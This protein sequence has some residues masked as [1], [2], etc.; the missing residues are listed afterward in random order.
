[1][2]CAA[3]TGSH[4]P[5]ATPA[6]GICYL[7]A[8]MSIVAC[9]IASRNY[10]AYARVFA[11]S[12]REHHPGAEVVLCLVDEPAAGDDHTGEPFN[13]VFA[14]DLDI[15]GFRSLA[16]RYGVL[17]LNTAVKPFLLRH[18]RDRRGVDRCF[19]FDPDIRVLSPL[20]ELARLLDHHPLLLTPHRLTPA[21]D[22][23]LVQERM[24]L[25]SGAYNLGFLGLRLDATTAPFLDWWAERLRRFCRHDVSQGLF[26]DQR[27]M[28][29]APSLVAD[30]GIVRDPIY[31]V[32]YWNLVERRPMPMGGELQLDGRAL[33]FFH[34][35]GVDLD[36]LERVSRYQ[37]R[38]TLADRPEL[39]PLFVDYRDR[40]LA[41]GHR[42]LSPLP[43]SYGRFDNGVPL[44]PWVRRL[45]DTTDPAA[46]RW[47]DPFCVAAED[48][49][50]AWLTT[51]VW[52]D[53][54]P[55]SRAA[56]AVWSSSESLRQAIPLLAGGG[57]GELGR[58]LAGEGARWQLDPRLLGQPPE[59]AA[60]P[61]SPGDFGEQIPGAAVDPASPE[62]LL[63]WLND[64]IPGTA[65]RQPVITRFALMLHGRRPDLATA[66]PD[67][68]GR[69]QLRYAYWFCRWGAAE[70]AADRRLV[71]PIERTL[72][73]RSRFALVWHRRPRGTRTAT[74]E[75]RWT[76]P[77][78]LAHLGGPR[79]KLGVNVAGY[80][81]M[82]TG[83]A[84]AARGS[85]AA[86]AAAGM[87]TTPYT[88]ASAARTFGPSAG[89]DGT[90]WPLTLLHANA[91]E[92]P[93]ALAELGEGAR[94]AGPVVGYWFWELA[95]FPL[96]YAASFA[97]LAEVWTASS[98]AAA[99]IAGL[100]PV[101][102]RV[103]APHVP[104]PASDPVERRLLGIGELADDPR[105]LLILVSFDAR[106]GPE[107]KN[108]WAAIAALRELL[109][110]GVPGGRP[111]GLVLR[112]HG[113]GQAAALVSGL[114]EAARGLPVTVDTMPRTTESHAALVAASDVVLSLHRAEGLG[115]LPIEAAYRG[116]VVVATDYGGT[117]DLVDATTGFPVP[118]RLVPLER[119]HGPYPRG[120]VWADPDIRAA[121]EALRRIIADPGA[122]ATRALAGQARA[123][124]LYGLAAASDRLANEVR[125]ILAAPRT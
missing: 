43:Y 64:P 30:A 3:R 94:L 114:R 90:P 70:V 46:R 22:A 7:P 57:A 18:L 93:R 109:A 116:R 122:A 113:A 32:A 1:M 8:S 103:V 99:A 19:Y 125:R 14:R 65:A 55:L 74:A 36:D 100:A 39:R 5:R 59:P 123:R 106:S 37:D 45:L 13:V 81:A 104:E 108:P 29:L 10:L 21:D 31:N 79:P 54:R 105:R 71:V 27:W 111:V 83:V 53:G 50:Y 20:D 15:P 49:F 51:P 84:N 41:A 44:A 62:P 42:E 12:Y 58:R 77:P 95:H 24:L 63:D 9:T 26:V 16:F 61:P 121:A 6:D 17:E 73:L 38:L 86:L 69:D 23:D 48:S 47:P 66:Y 78:A 60:T 28:D 82:E 87:P 118:C 40:L 11:Q 72:P 75:T 115:M 117:T 112:V 92:T 34:F 52:V 25:L 98:F 102:V 120:A 80:F 2:R 110:S 119:D 97:G 107:R 89:F 4:A 35:S 76:P 96:A 33:G 91:D 67:P 68:L 88:L 124:A 56:V 101:P 85:L